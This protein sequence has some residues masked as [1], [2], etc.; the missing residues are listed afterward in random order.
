M[1]CLFLISAVMAALAASPCLA[2]RLPERWEALPQIEDVRFSEKAIGFIARDGRRFVLDRA[3]RSFTRV[4]GNDF[5]SRFAR[6]GGKAPTESIEDKGIGSVY[7]LRA[8]DGTEFRAQNAYCAEGSDTPHLLLLEGSPIPSH[9]ARCVSI[10]SVEIID[11]AL[12]LGTRYDG[13][14]GEY[15]GQGVVIQ[16]R[17]TTRPIAELDV[18]AGMTGN[19]IRVIRLDPYS[20]KVLVVTEQGFNEAA[21]DRSSLGA[22]YFYD[23]FDSASGKTTV[24]LSSTP[25]AGNDLATVGRWLAPEDPMAYFEAAT[26]IPAEARGKFSLY[27]FQQE[28][29]S[30]S[31]L[32]EEM[33]V[34]IPFLLEA[35]KARRRS[36]LDLLC[37]FQDKRAIKF[38]LAL[39]KSAPADSADG[40]RIKRCLQKYAALDLLTR[41]LVPEREKLLLD[42]VST[43][44]AE[45]ASPGEPSVA[46]GTLQAVIE[47][48]RALMEMGDRRGIEMINDHF[49]ASDGNDG[50]AELFQGVTM[51]LHMYEEI[52]PSVLAG[53]RKFPMNRLSQ[54]C[55]F[56]DMSYSTHGES[57]CNAEHAAA[58]VEA[59]ERFDVGNGS[60]ES[61]FGGLAEKT[62]IKAF[63]SQMGNKAVRRDF[64][65]RIYPGLSAGQKRIVQRLRP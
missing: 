44:L 19:L 55:S 45:L 36:A 42:K 18:K 59:L 24:L 53:L 21:R 61:N 29:Y 7:L 15:P 2:G 47:N 9:A 46:Y 48:T 16:D 64:F 3:S 65:K 28:Q 50:D 33:Q 41:D 31:F 14:Y 57:R 43:A 4:E 34:L 52:T 27:Y 35:A 25:R 38:F 12:W 30:D 54:S 22:K 10:S 5:S 1:C 17:K 8:S 6:T 60:G 49:I 32:P 26:G 37:L 39:E 62:C 40:W 20:G 11:D 13:E 58:I 56:L 23:E 51:S 63:M